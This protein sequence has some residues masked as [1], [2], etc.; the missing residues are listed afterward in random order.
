MSESF[1]TPN[2]L[3]TRLG[4]KSDKVRAWINAGQLLAVNV[5]ENP[6][7]QRPRWRIAESEVDRF[8]QSRSNM[9][10]AKTKTVQRRRKTKPARQW[11]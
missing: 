5:A 2:A 8:L 4:I 7:G 6:N 10:A 11:V 3:A 1:T 9:P